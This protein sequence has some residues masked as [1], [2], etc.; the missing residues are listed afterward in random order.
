[1]VFLKPFFSALFF[2]FFFSPQHTILFL[3]YLFRLHRR[4][5]S[6]IVDN[7]TL[8]LVFFL[9]SRSLSLVLPLRF[10]PPASLS[11]CTA[12]CVMWVSWCVGVWMW[13][14]VRMS[15]CQ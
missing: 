3:P 11:L 8:P 9:S 15:S 13:M 5:N 14:C 1:M 4:L 12:W 10:P 6:Y 7:H 2:L